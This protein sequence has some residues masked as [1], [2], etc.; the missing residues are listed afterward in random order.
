MSLLKGRLGLVIPWTLFVLVCIGW[1]VFWFAAKDMAVARLDAAIAQAR[2]RGV[3]A[4][5][6]QVR[7][8]GYPLHLT[9][10]LSEAHVQMAPLPR[11]DFVSLPVSVNLVDPSHL[12]VDLKDGV[13][14]TGRDGAP[15]VIDPV[16]GAMSVHWQGR[17][18]KRVS[19]DLEGAPAPHTLV[20]IR[21]DARTPDA[22]QVAIDI[23]GHETDTG[24]RLRIGVVVDHT[25]TLAQARP[26]DPLGAWVDAG[27]AAK[28][29]ALE[30]D[31][32]GSKIT[33]AGTLR[34]DGMRRPE[35]AIDLQIAGGANGLMALFGGQNTRTSG[36][37]TLRVQ[38]GAWRLGDISAPA[39]PLYA[40]SPSSASA[41]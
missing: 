19:L 2:A 13:R 34:L 6:A 31:W 29:E 26:G 11:L 33:G 37:A 22:W 39:R 35:G 16:R 28:I 14:W 30:L 40:L 7:A 1:T 36:A 15:H 4:G 32:H 12:I 10:T 27:G 18:L 3:E 25:A 24:E 9:L 38:D 20:H 5:Y 41:P 23:A 8:S 21:P 17:T